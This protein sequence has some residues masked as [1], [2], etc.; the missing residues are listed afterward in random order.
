MADITLEMTFKEPDPDD[1][2]DEKDL[3]TIELDLNGVEE[4]IKVLVAELFQLVQKE[5]ANR[6]SQ[7]LFSLV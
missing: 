7:Y 4:I 1:S 2:E 6:G 5:S 3:P